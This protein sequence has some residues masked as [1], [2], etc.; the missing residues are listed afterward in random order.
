MIAYTNK[1]WG[2]QAY[3]DALFKMRPRAGVL[4]NTAKKAGVVLSS[5]I[6]LLSGENICKDS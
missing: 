2:K 5:V 3:L 6:D 4:H 1:A